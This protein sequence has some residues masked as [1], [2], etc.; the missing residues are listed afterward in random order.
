[1]FIVFAV[2][3]LRECFLFI[4]CCRPHDNSTPL[5]CWFNDIFLILNIVGG[6]E[7]GFLLIQIGS[8]LI[9][10]VVTECLVNGFCN[11]ANV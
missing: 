3:E 8:E 1:M 11:G 9:M 5:V 10:R 2:I 6:K 4:V 7:I